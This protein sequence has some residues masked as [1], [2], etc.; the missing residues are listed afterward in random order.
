M[1][2]ILH[3]SGLQSRGIKLYG[4][5]GAAGLIAAHNSKCYADHQ[6]QYGVVTLTDCRSVLEPPLSD[7]NFDTVIDDSD[8]Q[9][10]LVG[11]DDYMGC[12]SC[13]GIAPSIA[14]FDT[15]RNGR[16]DCVCVLS[17]CIRGNRCRSCGAG[18]KHA[19]AKHPSMVS[20]TA[21]VRLMPRTKNTP[22]RSSKL[23]ENDD[24]EVGKYRCFITE[25]GNSVALKES[26]ITKAVSILNED[27]VASTVTPN[28]DLV[29]NLQ[30]KFQ[31]GNPDLAKL[32]G[33]SI[34]AGLQILVLFKEVMEHWLREGRGVK[35][36][37]DFISDSCSL[38]VEKI[39]HGAL[40]TLT[41]IPRTPR[42]M[43]APLEKP[44]L[45]QATTKVYTH[46]WIE[47]LACIAHE[48]ENT[49]C[50]KVGR[51]Q[52]FDM[53]HTKKDGTPMTADAAKIMVR[54]LGKL[55]EKRAEYHATASSQGIVNDD[56]IEN[57]AINDVLGPERYGRK[58]GWEDQ[59][60]ANLKAEN[61]AREAERA[62][63]A[64]R[65]AV[66]AQR[67]STYQQRCEEFEK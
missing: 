4:A 60:M 59:Q 29:V 35:E 56:D 51:I 11:E 54:L 40:F 27:E 48:E 23:I 52:L 62:A 7:H 66:A 21:M 26:S 6:K 32:I 25:F 58:V 57:Q 65:E 43:D 24:R 28:R 47:E 67:E 16:L 5:L 17:R 22:R 38:E 34:L 2:K 9:Q 53:T 37:N 64:E 44:L 19:Q 49:S 50:S 33:D 14:V 31:R 45:F 61:E 1:M 8:D 15:I 55:R 46:G 12:A 13:H 39:M 20:N 42:Y 63:E 3:F 41:I 10:K 18:Y 30:R 36:F